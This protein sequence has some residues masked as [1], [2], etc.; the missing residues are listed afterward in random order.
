MGINFPAEPA[1]SALSFHY[2]SV[3][4]ESENFGLAIKSRRLGVLF[5]SWY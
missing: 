1:L 4:L 3:H 2:V 5:K